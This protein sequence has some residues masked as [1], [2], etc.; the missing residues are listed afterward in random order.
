METKNINLTY[1]N[2]KEEIKLNTISLTPKNNNQTNIIF[3]L[4]LNIN[5][6]IKTF[7]S[8][9]KNIYSKYQNTINPKNNYSTLKSY[10][11][12]SNKNS[13]SYLSRTQTKTS[14]SNSPKFLIGI[15]NI[16][17]T[18]NSKIQFSALKQNSFL[19]KKRKYM[20]SEEIELE[21]IEK[22]RILSKKLAEKNKITYYKSLEYTPLK[23]SPTPLT[24][25]KPFNLS[26]NKNNK[27]L[28]EGKSSTLYE[29]HKLNQKI[30]LKMQQKIEVSEDIKTKNQI[31]LNDTDYLRKQNLLYNDLFKAPKSIIKEELNV[32][33]NNNNKI[34][35]SF[36]EN[37]DI[38]KVKNYMTPIKKENVNFYLISQK[39]QFSE[40]NFGKSKI[41]NY[42]LTNIKKNNKE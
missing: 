37:K 32:H 4:K 24:T 21:K 40:S 33:K 9:A 30:R 35:N 36:E 39:K 7:Y 14:I 27:Y 8:S 13:F 1:S 12:L 10:P 38:N 20:T 26:C 5:P 31:L 28:K 3:P 11:S 23:I 41:I 2:K 29:I 25:F 15:K 16:L 22:E 42:Y 19:N 34:G 6:F 18:K 17:A